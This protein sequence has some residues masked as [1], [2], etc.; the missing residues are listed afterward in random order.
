MPPVDH[1]DDA[2]VVLNNSTNKSFNN[3]ANSNNSTEYMSYQPIKI[4]Y[5]PDICKPMVGE[6]KLCSYNYWCSV[7]IK[8]YYWC[9]FNGVIIDSYIKHIICDVIT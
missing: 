5:P 8:L 4:P 7:Y 1:I 9:N 3:T 6:F 2:T